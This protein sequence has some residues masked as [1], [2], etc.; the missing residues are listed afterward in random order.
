MQTEYHKKLRNI[1][2]N[3]ID[4]ICK[5][6]G[7]T[8][9]DGQY[10]DNYLLSATS[11]SGNVRN[12]NHAVNLIEYLQEEFDANLE[13]FKMTYIDVVEHLQ[14]NGYL[15]ETTQ[16][17]GKMKFQCFKNKTETITKIG[18]EF[19]NKEYD[20]VSNLLEDFSLVGIR[21]MELSEFH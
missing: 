8:E 15:F 18:H 4:F 21:D 14:A 16:K 3:S 13:P 1:A 5:T 17:N 12:Y 10:Y 6:Y 19:E 20:Y 7:Y 11:K 9:V 2:E